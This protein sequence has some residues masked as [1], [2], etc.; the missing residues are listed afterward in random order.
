MRTIAESTISE[1]RQPEVAEQERA[2][3]RA[4]P[5]RGAAVRAR[6]RPHAVPLIVMLAVAA[7]VIGW[8]IIKYPYL[9][10]IDEN[11]HF[12]YVRILPD[13]P[14]GGS[15]LSQDSLRMTACRGYPPDLFDQGLATY[16][17][18]ACR[19]K[20]FDPEAFPGGGKSTAGSTAPLYYFVTA[21]LTRPI[22]Y[23]VDGVPL[24]LLIRIVNTLWLAGLMVVGYAIAR[25]LKA[26]ATAATAAA[27]LVGASSDVVTSSATVGPDTFTAMLGGIVILLAL[28]Y[29]GSRRALLTL[30]GVVVAAA[31]TKLTAVTAVGVAAVILVLLPLLRERSA[32]LLKRVARP[33]GLAVLIS[34]LFAALSAA[35]FL[36]PV[37]EGPAAPELPPAA[38]PWSQIKAQLFF[39][40][41][42][43]NAGNFNAPFLDSAVNSRLEGL[44]VGVLS[45]AVLAGLVAGRRYLDA[46]VLAIG[47]L[48]MA[49]VGPVVL[50]ALNLYGNNLY[51]ALP[52]RYGY[53]L[54]AG[55]IAL[56]GW[57]FRSPALARALA[58]LAAATYLSVFF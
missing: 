57:A 53:G 9:S 28:R 37:P 16:D 6:L 52:P 25:R 32:P 51:F 58:V 46:R 35:W 21:A 33:F 23:V 39:N 3:H 18:P 43:P 15:T 20:H 27:V 24:L 40:F 45:F 2:D 47:M 30:I 10:P 49:V 41:F 11:A 22:A 54:L 55:F 17:W 8:H 1:G 4:R 5:A 29:D 44:M 36:R 42:T 7:S 34:F 19:S 56:G 31:V 12:D 48:V 13:V 14:T 50:T 38:V 26:S